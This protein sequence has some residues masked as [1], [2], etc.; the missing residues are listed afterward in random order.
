M[1]RSLF[2][3]KEEMK[4][5]YNIDYALTEIVKIKNNS[6]SRIIDACPNELLFRNFDELEIKN[7]NV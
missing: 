6:Y 1:K 7:I 3:K 2:R 4:H 5:K